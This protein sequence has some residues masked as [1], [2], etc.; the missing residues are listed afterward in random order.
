MGEFMLL[1]C[2]VGEDSWTERRPN[3]SILKPIS[4]GFSLEGLMLKKL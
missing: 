2:S 3:E 1:N 4:P